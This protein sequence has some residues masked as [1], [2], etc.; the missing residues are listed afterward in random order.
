[1]E[2]EPRTPLAGMVRL[3]LRR[4][5][6]NPGV[7]VNDALFCA[8]GLFVAL[9][10]AADEP[11]FVVIRLAIYLITICIGG[12]VMAELYAKD[13]G[14]LGMLM[15]RGAFFQSCAAAIL[16]Q[17]GLWQL[18]I[19][20]SLGARLFRAPDTAPDLLVQWLATLGCALAVAAG[21]LWITLEAY[22]RDWTSLGPWFLPSL[23]IVFLAVFTIAGIG[24][25]GLAEGAAARQ[26]IAVAYT[27]AA[28]LALSAAM[29][30][31][32][33]RLP[34]RIHPRGSDG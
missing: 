1:M 20:P 4:A 10:R 32:A 22:R 28:A 29:T 15:E 9:H 14:F 2:S 24:L 18:V 21:V 11:L 31:T 7:L 19:L 26:W 17:I 3:E 13:P 5:F 6:R 34:R 33:R 27:W 23:A 25:L 16:T 12:I 30:S 8:V